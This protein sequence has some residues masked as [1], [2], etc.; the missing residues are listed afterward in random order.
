[1]IFLATILREEEISDSNIELPS[2]GPG[3]F[4]KLRILRKLY[5]SEPEQMYIFIFANGR[6]QPCCSS[7]K[8][9]GPLF[10]N[11]NQPYHPNP[12]CT[13]PKCR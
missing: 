12:M 6:P 5:I 7:P 4:G 10:I 13:S 3:R 2:C 1:M 8:K 9:F 11:R